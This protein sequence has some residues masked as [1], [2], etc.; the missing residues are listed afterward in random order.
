M[1]VLVQDI[2]RR[3]FA[4]FAPTK[5]L[6]RDM[7]HAANSVLACRTAAMGGHVVRCP[8][9]H[10]QRIV[11]NS[12]RHRSCPG[13]ALL[14]REQWLD[15][16]GQR[17]LDCPHYHVV[18][19]VPH[20][21][22]T[23]WR[24]NR[25][26]FASALFAAAAGALKKLLADPKYL[27]AM[28]GLL[29]ALHTWSQTLATH[30]HLHVLVTG[31]GIDANQHWR[32]P[33]K[34][35]L[36]PRRVLMIIFRGKLRSELL[37]RLQRGELVLP[38]SQTTAQV[39]S[40]LNRLGR[41]VWNV[42]IL[43]RYEH[44]VGVLTYL[45]RYLKGGPIAASRFLAASHDA[46]R[47][48]CRGNSRD[49]EGSSGECRLTT[50]EFFTRLLNHV[51]PRSM[52]TVRGY[53]LYAGGQRRQLNTARERLGQTAT[54]ADSHKRLRWQDLC[55]RLGRSSDTTCG[56]CSAPLVIGLHFLPGRPPPELR[57]TGS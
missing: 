42:K 14:A 10:Q 16:W 25:R 20:D 40:L 36:L 8:Q 18:F 47:F 31:G 45:A 33:V 22:N 29:A 28:P 9:G 49:G 56:E 6:S 46:V 57:M 30:V 4:R 43:P 7:W 35:C 55:E 38:P 21:L 41:Q 32:S 27:G 53:G 19:T 24:F 34:S 5:R 15:N 11:Y 17:M 51:P 3:S 1:G 13:C 37:C 26:A 48:R 23:L 39:R 44:G 54:V 50:T 12:C 2:F 52:Q